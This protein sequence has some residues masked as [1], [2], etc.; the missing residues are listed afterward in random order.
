MNQAGDGV[1]EFQIVVANGMPADYEASGFGHFCKSAA[2][3]L[4]ENRRIAALRESNERQR[5]NWAPPH[6]VNV[7]ERV[8]GGDLSEKIWVVNNRREKISGLYQS[9]IRRD[10]IDAGIIAGLKSDQN[11]CVGLARKSAQ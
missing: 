2:H 6:G 11:I 3:D 7:T 4:I 10:A 9:D 8:R 5:G 1:A